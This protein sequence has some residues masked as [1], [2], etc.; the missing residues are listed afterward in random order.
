MNC[1]RRKS[2]IWISHPS[3]LK[4]TVDIGIR[5]FNAIVMQMMDKCN[6]LRND[7]LKDK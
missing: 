2:E 4:A 5:N 7:Y 1:S 3:P 6:I